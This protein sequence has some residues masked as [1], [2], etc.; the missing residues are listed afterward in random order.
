MSNREQYLKQHISCGVITALINDQPQTVS[1]AARK[2]T[3]PPIMGDNIHIRSLNNGP[4]L[5][6]R[7]T[8]VEGD[9]LPIY[10]L[11]LEPRQPVAPPTT[12]KT[13]RDSVIKAVIE[14]KE[15]TM[16]VTLARPK[17]GQRVKACPKFEAIMP[18]SWQVYQVVNID[19]QGCTR[20][21]L[22]TV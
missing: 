12:P 3:A 2:T 7:V 17:V 18:K 6:C 8:K 1:L 15:I 21:H 4:W 10:H 13:K 9:T 11:T 22:K 20:Y 16:R 5:L 14:G 19:H